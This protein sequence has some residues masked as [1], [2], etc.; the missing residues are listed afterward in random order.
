MSKGID[1]S[2]HQGI[3]NWQKVKSAGVEF[4]IIKAGGSDKGTYTDECF[5]T[6]YRGAKSVGIHVG[7]YY[8]VGKNCTSK[9]DGVADAKRFSK[10]I[11]GKQFEYPVYIDLEATSPANRAGATDACIGFCEYMESQ[12]YYCGIY[13]SDISGF[14]DR[15]D[16]SRLDDYDKWVARYGSAPVVVKKY[17]IWQNSETGRVSGINGNVDTD[18]CYVDYPTLIRNA[19]KNGYSNPDLLPYIPHMTASECQTYLAWCAAKGAG[20]YRDTAEDFKRFVSGK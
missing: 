7:A 3:I 13:A 10:I 2:H 19:G 12:G 18:V 11:E 4:A 6:N 16:L 5:E 15:L 1:V 17:G 14:K 8:Y 20:D 9:A